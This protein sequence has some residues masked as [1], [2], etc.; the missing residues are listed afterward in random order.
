LSRVNFPS[1]D[2]YQKW[3]EWGS[4]FLRAVSAALSIGATNIG[5]VSD[6][7]GTKVPDGWLLCDGTSF[8]RVGYPELYVTLG[9]SNVLPNLTSAHGAGYIVGIKAA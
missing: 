4:A 7:R 2:H 8:S 1:T 3:E 5:Q 6:F 9:N